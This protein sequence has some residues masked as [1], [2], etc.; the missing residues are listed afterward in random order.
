M[1]VQALST[2]ISGLRVAQLQLDT[3]ARNTANVS[4]PGYTRKNLPI[5][6]F[7]TGNIAGG[8]RAG[9]LERY[10][11][12][13]LQRDLW[14]QQSLSHFHETKASMLDRVQRLHGSPE[15][16]NSIASSLSQL[17]AAFNTLTTSPES[18]LNH[19]DT[20]NKALATARQFNSLSEEITKLRN[21]AQTQI[22]ETVDRINTNLERFAKLNQSIAA[23]N[24][25]GR[26][27]VA[28]LDQ[29]DEV[30]KELS[31][32]LEIS[33][34][35]RGDSVMV[36]QSKTGRLLADTQAQSLSF[37]ESP[38]NFDSV[39]PGTFDGS[40]RLSDGTPGT[41]LTQESIGGRLGALVQVRDTDL[42]RQQAQLDELAFRTAQRLENAGLQLFVD[43]RTGDMPV[44]AAGSYV[45]FSAHIAVEQAIVDAPRL[46]RDGF[47]PAAPPPHAAP[48]APTAADL[49][50]NTV[51]LDIVNQAFGEFAGAGPP[52]V[53]HPTFNTT[54][55]GPAGANLSTDL[56]ATATLEDYAKNMIVKQAEDH[57]IAE[58]AH[59]FE[60]D[61]FETLEQRFLNESAVDLDEEVAQLTELQN[62]YSSSARM[63]QTLQEMFDQLLNSV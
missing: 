56:P 32:D 61:F 1:T 14:A 5:E 20:L 23:E 34:F 41:D 10:V 63:I 59:E 58:Q 53:A 45:G 38:V 62:S 39:H 27:D 13:A 3:T 7:F 6:S 57:S 16:Q 48:P 22:D 24:A 25:N 18:E 12:Q 26:S 44:D 31:K 8:A 52:P 2:A 30:V 4:T 40:I 60:A 35:T 55:L 51:P 54:G 36:L 33:Q 42:P 43:D 19:S 11:D 49:G 47:T 46:V 37:T 9:E 21:D 28:L 29:R 17:N 50:D 15:D